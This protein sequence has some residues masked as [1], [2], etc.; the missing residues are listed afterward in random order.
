[1]LWQGEETTIAAAVA[2]TCSGPVHTVM[3]LG[4]LEDVL[5]LNDEFAALKKLLDPCS[6]LI[7]ILS[8]PDASVAVR[9][10]QTPAFTSD[11]C[12]T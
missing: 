9:K 6:A 2:S 5:D 3:L 11:L 12:S 10:P 1:M 4:A 8:S 7:I